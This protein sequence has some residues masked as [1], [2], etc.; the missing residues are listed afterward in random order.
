M[1]AEKVIRPATKMAA[2]RP[3]WC[4]CAHPPPTRRG[5]VKARR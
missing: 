5:C 1:A 3:A 4:R 2:R